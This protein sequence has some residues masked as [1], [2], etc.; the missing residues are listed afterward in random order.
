MFIVFSHKQFQEY[1][2]S[3]PRIPNDTLRNNA[4]NVSTYTLFVW[5]TLL[6]LE[7]IND[8]CGKIMYMTAMDG[9]F[10]VVTLT[11]KASS[12]PSVF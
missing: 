6:R 11:L 9:G 1:Y 12:Y 5:I 2:G 8:N 7:E 10:I 4:S 3:G